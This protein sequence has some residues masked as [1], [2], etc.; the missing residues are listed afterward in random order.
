M[1]VVGTI[2]VKDTAVEERQFK[3]KNGPF[4]IRKQFGLARVGDEIRRVAIQLAGD[5]APYPPGTYRSETDCTVG[6]YGDV[7]A[8]RSLTL[9]PAK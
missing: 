8:P 4:S 7:L 9:Q 6:Q 1:K 5:Q 2:E 3:G